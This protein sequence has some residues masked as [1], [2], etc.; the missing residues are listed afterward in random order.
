MLLAK[1][2]LTL[3]DPVD[4][5]LPGSSI[6]GILQVR[7]L[8]WVAFPFSRGSSQTQELNLGLLHCR[9]ILYHL[10]HQGSLITDFNGHE[11]EQT[12][13]D[14]EGQGSLAYFSPCRSQRVGRDLATE[15]Q[16]HKVLWVVKESLK[17]YYRKT[18]I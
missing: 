11:V 18:V 5:S 4:C 15:Q 13:G 3:P 2:C 7:V 6:H 10:S 1:S 12:P 9:Q 16:Q 14:S 17:N 8:E